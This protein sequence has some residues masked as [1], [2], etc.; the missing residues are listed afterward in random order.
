LALRWASHNGHT[1]TVKVL[2]AA[3]ADV[4]ADN[5]YALQWACENGHTETVKVLLDAGAD[6]HADND[7]ALRWASNYGHTETVKVLLAAGADVHAQDDYAL[8]WASEHGHTETVKV[9]LAAGADVHAL[10]WASNYGH[11]E[12]VKV[13]KDW[14]AKEKG[15][16]ESINF[17]RGLDPKK[18]MKTGKFAPRYFKTPEEF[19]DYIIKMLPEIF[20][21]EIP[22]DILSKKDVGRI[23]QCYYKKIYNYLKEQ[24]ILIAN[25]NIN[26]ISE[27]SLNQGYHEFYYWPQEIRKKLIKLGYSE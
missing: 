18:S 12:T 24:D 8:R 7:Y 23:P 14:I 10:R 11:T 15:L 6:V 9:L 22:D 17:E 1:E 13:L 19:H 27:H 3:G 20:D 16:K 5:D 26:P 25:T 4:H 21:G 2:L